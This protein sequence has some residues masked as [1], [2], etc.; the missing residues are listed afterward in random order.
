MSNHSQAVHWEVVYDILN[1]KLVTINMHHN[2]EFTFSQYIKYFYSILMCAQQ[3][4]MPP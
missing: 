3:T 1:S 4:Q 2:L